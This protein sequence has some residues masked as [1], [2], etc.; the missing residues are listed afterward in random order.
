MS[1]KWKATYSGHKDTALMINALLRYC[2]NGVAFLV[3][4]A[5]KKSKC[6]KVQVEDNTNASRGSRLKVECLTL[7]S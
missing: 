6:F 4:N 1:N 7:C 2:D 3:N 5:E